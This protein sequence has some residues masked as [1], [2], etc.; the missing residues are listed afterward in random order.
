MLA[1]RT[2]KTNSHTALFP[3]FNCVKALAEYR[4]GH[5]KDAVHFAAEALNSATPVLA[6]DAQAGAILAMAKYRLGSPLTAREAL[7][8]AKALMPESLLVAGK[9]P[10]E[11]DGDWHDLLIAQVLVREANRVLELE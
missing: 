8:K 5:W 4:R 11:F 10:P 9:I 3:Y 6:R 1:D 2:V 7:A